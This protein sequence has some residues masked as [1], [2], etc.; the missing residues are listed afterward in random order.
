MVLA[1]CT[2]GVLIVVRAGVSERG[3]VVHAVT[4]LEYAQ[5]KIL[6]F[7]LNGVNLES[8]RHYPYGRYHYDQYRRNFGKI[9][10][11]GGYDRYGN[12]YGRYGGY[13]G[14]GKS[15]YGY[16]SPYGYGYG[17]GHVAPYVEEEP[18][19]EDNR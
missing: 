4:Q 12:R 15:G 13:G 18:V 3:P 14:Y 8:R 17:Y 7:V 6:G 1:P 9:S 16:G 19:M 2:D 10:G 5:A 11:Y